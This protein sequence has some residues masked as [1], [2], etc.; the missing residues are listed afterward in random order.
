MHVSELELLI[1][2]ELFEHYYQPIFEMNS[3]K[4]FGREL[5]LRANFGSPE[6]IFHK[7]KKTNKLYEIDTLSIN[8]AIRYL[9]T[10][11]DIWKEEFLFINVYPSTIMEPLFPSFINQLFR[12]HPINCNQIVFELN[13]TEKVIDLG[14]LKKRLAMLKNYGCK[15]AFDDVGKGWSSLSYI[16]EVE[17]HFIKLDR[18]FSIDLNES[19]KKQAMISAVSSYCKANNIDI[20]LEGI[21][22]FEDLQAAEKTGVGMAQ[23]YYL[24]RPAKM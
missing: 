16:I 2:K 10:F 9:T 23:G 8:K 24:G 20:I 14:L 12:E 7:A 3:E 17:P 1:E 18:Y 11:K 4:P 6:F 5:L 21:E 15:I 22:T 13:E 19:P